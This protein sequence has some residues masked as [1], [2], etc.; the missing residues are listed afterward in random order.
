MEREHLGRIVRSV[1]VYAGHRKEKHLSHMNMP[2]VRIA[3]SISKVAIRSIPDGWNLAPGDLRWLKKPHGL[4]PQPN[5]PGSASR[6]R[7]RHSVH[8]PRPKPADRRPRRTRRQCLKSSRAR[9][10]RNLRA[11]AIGKTKASPRISEPK[12]KSRATCAAF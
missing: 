4:Q 8:S 2:N 9:R 3:P 6:L 12:T 7:R 11:T 5:Y 1:A 10:V